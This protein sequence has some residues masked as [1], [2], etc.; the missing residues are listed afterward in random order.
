MGSKPQTSQKPLFPQNYSGA[1]AGFPEKSYISTWDAANKPNRSTDQL[2]KDDF[3]KLCR[4]AYQAGVSI[5]YLKTEVGK[6]TWEIKQD[7]S[8]VSNR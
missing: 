3:G 8:T 4:I 2:T 1:H 7:H 5:Y 6:D